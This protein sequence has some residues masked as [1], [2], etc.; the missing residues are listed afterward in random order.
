MLAHDRFHLAVKSFLVMQ[1]TLTNILQPKRLPENLHRI[2]WSFDRMAD[3]SFIRIDLVVIT[4]LERLVAE[5][6]DVFIVDAG[7]LFLGFDVSEGVG[8]VPAGGEDVEGDLAAD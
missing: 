7:H 4:A 5:E 3:R 2:L 8:L 1:P 6:V